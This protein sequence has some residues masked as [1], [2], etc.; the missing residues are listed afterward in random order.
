MNSFQQLCAAAV[1]TLWLT[2]PAFA[3]DMQT[4]GT[5]SSDGSQTSSSIAGT[6]MELAIS[7][8]LNVSSLL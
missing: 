2:I 7:Y 4:P 3:G 8:W 6:V 5:P 1:L